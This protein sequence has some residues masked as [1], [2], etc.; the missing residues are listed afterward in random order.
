MVESEAGSVGQS[1]AINY[2]VAAEMG[3][4]G[5]SNLEAARILEIQEHLKELK[6][7]YRNQVAYGQKPTDKE[8]DACFFQG[9]EDSSG[10]ADGSKRSVRFLKGHLGRIEKDIGDGYAVGGQLSL[11]DI[12]LYNSLAE[13]LPDQQSAPTVAQHRREPFGSKARM[14]KVLAG[15]PK[16]QKSVQNVASA[17]AISKYLTNRGVQRF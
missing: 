8:L 3:L 7:A 6:E 4:L 9:A 13:Y 14:D 11:A 17:P 15:Y 2:F 5:A 12:A 1:V 16:I 10:A